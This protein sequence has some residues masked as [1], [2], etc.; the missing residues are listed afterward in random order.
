MSEKPPPDVAHIERVPPKAA[1]IDH[2]HRGDLVL[3]VLDDDTL[4]RRRASP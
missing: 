1:P 2:V 4:T 3:G